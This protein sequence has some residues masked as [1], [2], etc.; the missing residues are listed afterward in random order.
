MFNKFFSYAGVYA[1]WAYI[2]TKEGQG[3]SYEAAWVISMI[4]QANWPFGRMICE[5]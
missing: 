5:V 3:R 1:L 4:F 2:K